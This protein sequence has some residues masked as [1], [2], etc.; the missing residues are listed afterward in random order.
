MASRNNS[1]FEPHPVLS[2]LASQHKNDQASLK[3]DLIAPYVPVSGPNFNWSRFALNQSYNPPDDLVGPTG[4]PPKIRLTGELVPDSTEDHGLDVEVPNFEIES[5]RSRGDGY[6]PTEF[7]TTHAT[8]LLL[9]RREI[10]MATELA[11]SANY[12]TTETLAGNAQLSDKINSDPV[13]TLLRGK[14]KSLIPV[15]SLIF[16]SEYC[17]DTI[18]SHPNIIGW[19]SNGLNSSGVVTEEQIRIA[20]NLAQVITLDAQY[21]TSNPGQTD[22]FSNVIDPASNNFLVFAKLSMGQVPSMIQPNPY[23]MFTPRW[24]QRT[25]GFVPDT[26]M[27]VRGGGFARVYEA[28]KL[29]LVSSN[30]AH[31]IQ[32]VV[33]NE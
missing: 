1:N 21:L 33:A 4:T 6:D 28:R 11:N 2:A 13:G 12:A 8:D 15:N 3:A 18:L 22:T 23:F 16:S 29:T 5:A 7:G 24:G 27:G 31:L 32:D 20:L 10:E 14:R 26:D 9:L 19:I 25:A 17:R 30:C